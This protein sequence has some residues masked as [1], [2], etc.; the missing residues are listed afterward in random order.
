MVAKA[1]TLESATRRAGLDEEPQQHFG[2]TKT[3]ERDTSAVVRDER[4]VGRRLS[5][6]DHFNSTRLNSHRWFNSTGRGVAP[7]QTRK[8]DRR[9]RMRARLRIRR[10]R[11]SPFPWRRRFDRGS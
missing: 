4:E 10:S 2:A 9:A 11:A 7:A 6:F 8:L 5:N 3:R 1:A